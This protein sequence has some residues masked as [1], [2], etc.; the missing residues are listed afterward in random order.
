LFRNKNRTDGIGTNLK[1]GIKVYKRSV[2]Q[3]NFSRRCRKKQSAKEFPIIDQ[4]FLEVYNN[5]GFA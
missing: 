4:E 3:K 5:E 2:C 1:D